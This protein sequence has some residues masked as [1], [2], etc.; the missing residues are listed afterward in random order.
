[1]LLISFYFLI[2]FF[3]IFGIIIFNINIELGLLFFS[4]LLSHSKQIMK[5]HDRQLVVIDDPVA[6]LCHFQVTL[7]ASNIRSN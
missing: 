2:I 6:V 7:Y 3:I 4:I 1:M 5:K